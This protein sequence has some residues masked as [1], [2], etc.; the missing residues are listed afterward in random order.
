MSGSQSFVAESA[1]ASV[2][3]DQLTVSWPPCVVTGVQLNGS[4][5]SV[6]AH[7]LRPGTQ[8]VMPHP[9]VAA[10]ST[11]SR[12]RLTRMAVWKVRWSHPPETTGIPLRLDRNF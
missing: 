8:S 6:V 11:A 9:A 7:H 12:S 10:A 3:H 1:L 4:G 5:S 2:G